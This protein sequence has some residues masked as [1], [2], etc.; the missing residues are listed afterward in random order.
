MRLSTLSLLLVLIGVVPSCRQ[1]PGS[2]A[3]PSSWRQTY[4]VTGMVKSLRPAEHEVGVEHQE[5]PGYMMAMTMPFS[6]RDTNELHGLIP[7]EEI[8]FTLIV[9]EDDSWIED[10][11]KTG[12]ARNILPENAGIRIARDVEAL[13]I[14]DPLPEYH[15][16]NEQGEPVS[17]SDYRGTALVLSFIFTRC[18]LPQY[19]PLTTKQLVATQETL[20]RGSAYP[21]N[22]QIL[23]ITLDP[24]FDTPA[25]LK[26]FGASYGYDPTRFRFLT[27]ELI[28][29]TALA[30]QFG[31]LFWTE[32]GT[33][34]HNLRTVVVG[35]DGIIRT[36][37]IGNEWS[38]DTLV[39]EVVQAAA[40]A[41]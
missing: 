31:L 33:I 22:W 6:V 13:V 37:M 41:P 4:A 2:D 21:T 27:G 20:K 7:G 34:N 12:V 1:E 16:I 28:E 15:F 18:P 3:A 35:A 36:N 30:E 32:D 23:A 17:L 26:Q 9:T 39:N 19:C 10:I 38:V 29:I 8:T 14:G 11:E 5:I 40:P 24:E 25:R